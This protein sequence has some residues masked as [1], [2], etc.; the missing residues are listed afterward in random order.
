MKSFLA[1][2]VILL[3]VALQ[4]VAHARINDLNLIGETRYFFVIS[5]FG[6]L[7]GGSIEV[8]VDGVSDKNVI[9]TFYC[10]VVS[11]CVNIT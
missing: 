6:I 3:V 10:E 8:Q 4:H 9:A 2:Q 5:S 11:Y 1:A 7:E